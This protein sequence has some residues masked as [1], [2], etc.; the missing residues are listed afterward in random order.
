MPE[1]ISL[2]VP[3]H[4]KY[5]NLIR[6]VA[7]CIVMGMGFS[8]KECTRTILALDEA[9]SNII[10]HSCGEDPNIKIDLTFCVKDD[11]LDIRIRDYGDCGTGFHPEEVPCKDTGE[12]KPGGFGLG[13]IKSIMDCVE[14]TPCTENGNV[15]KMSKKVK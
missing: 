11:R 12:V 6:K 14:F 13:L 8:E 3:S 2:S 15:L 7:D 4:S 5:L 9:C 10:R 1:E